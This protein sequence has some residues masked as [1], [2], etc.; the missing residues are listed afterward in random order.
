MN[1]VFPFFFFIFAFGSCCFIPNNFIDQFFLPTRGVII[2][3]PSFFLLFQLITCRRLKIPIVQLYPLVL[4]VLFAFIG[5]FNVNAEIFILLFCIATFGFITENVS[6][7]QSYLPLLFK[8]LLGLGLLNALV[9]IGQFFNLVHAFHPVY[10]ITGFFDNS[11]GLAIFLASIIPLGA[12]LLHTAKYTTR[13]II[14]IICGLM[15]L[16]ICM[17]GSRTGMVAVGLIVLIFICAK[18]DY[19]KRNKT[20]K[21]IFYIILLSIV[22]ILIGLYAF[23][24][25]SAEGRLFIW[26]V[27]SEM[28]WD[29]PWFGHGS[30]SFKAKYMNY[31]GEYFKTHPNSKFSYLADNVKHPFNEYLKIV[32]EHGFVG[33]LAILGYII[34]TVILTTQLLTREKKTAL[35]SL[36]V[37][38][39]GACFSYPFSY[40]AINVICALGFAILLHRSPTV[41]ISPIYRFI[42]LSI[43][44]LMLVG[45][46]YYAGAIW[47]WSKADSR[48]AYNKPSTVLNTYLELYPILKQ[49]GYFLYNYGYI[50]HQSK[51]YR[52]SVSINQEAL[53]YINNTDLQLMLADTYATLKQNHLAEMHYKQAYYMCPNRFMPLYG[54]FRLYKTANRTKE[55]L[56]IAQI[57]VNKSEKV[58]TPVVGLIKME[59][60]QFLKEKT[61]PQNCSVREGVLLDF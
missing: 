28:I 16:T 39:I 14:I 41:S 53:F 17:S 22:P 29:S 7:F 26:K 45:V 5:S 59:I 6:N 32:I 40:P 31:Q 9:G 24:K 20:L 51:Q 4:I 15:I 21:V 1:K 3:I 19:F 12:Y 25:E 42:T 46:I 58:T 8:G 33:I 47:H 23:K 2:I 30:E 36:L 35:Q 48:S 50:L 37:I 44:T 60:Q 11:A 56:E 57:I 27:S 10:K 38:A 61:D 52:M 49:N 13:I 55:A 43:I 54:L 34:L 18:Y